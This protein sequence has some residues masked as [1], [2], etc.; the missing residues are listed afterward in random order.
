VHGPEDAD[1]MV[2]EGAH[3]NG[4]TSLKDLPADCIMIFTDF[5]PTGKNTDKEKS[6]KEYL[7]SDLVLLREKAAQVVVIDHHPSCVNDMKVLKE[8]AELGAKFIDMSE[9]DAKKPKEQGGWP[10]GHCGASLVQEFCNVPGG[11][12]MDDEAIE[13]FWKLDVFFHQHPPEK[14]KEIEAKF[15]AFKGWINQNGMREVEMRLVETFMTEGEREKCFAKGEELYEPVRANTRKMA[16][17][18]TLVTNEVVD[19]RYTLKVYV[20]DIDKLKREGKKGATKDDKEI[21]PEVPLDPTVYQAEIDKLIEDKVSIAFITI[22]RSVNPKT[23]AWNL[24]LRRAGPFVDMGKVATVLKE[25]AK[26]AP[27]QFASGGGH[28]FAA[29][30][31]TTNKDLSDQQITDCVTAACKKCRIEPADGYSK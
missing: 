20:V 8:D 27:Y 28:A 6:S 26:D 30:A 3:G 17:S 22:E 31:Q 23:G 25:D 5:C 7:E 19:G 10:G 12:Q 29:G 4:G 1:I 16:T 14:A 9:T 13:M 21:D 2:I 18:A 11:Y 24:G 15:D